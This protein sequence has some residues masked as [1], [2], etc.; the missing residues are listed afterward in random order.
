LKT[1]L[2]ET[3]GPNI[4]SPF[5]LGRHHTLAFKRLNDWWEAV[6]WW[7]TLDDSWIN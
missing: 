1:E 7:I 3:S 5:R 2:T 4:L 6:K